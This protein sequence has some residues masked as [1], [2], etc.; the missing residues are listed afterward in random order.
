MMNDS[1]LSVPSVP[2]GQPTFPDL[3]GKRVLISG[4]GGG[5]GAA[6]SIG[7]L[8]QGCKV[9]VIDRDV[10]ALHAL[11]GEHPDL[12]IV[13]GDITDPATIDQAMTHGTVDVLVNNVANDMRHELADTDDATLQALFEVNLLAAMRLVRAVVPGMQAQSA[14]AILNIGSNS[15][16][17][18]LVGL[19]MY[20]ACK[21]AIHALT[22]AWAREYGSFDIRVN[23]LV[24]GW[25]FTDKQLRL[26][27]NPEAVAQCLEEQCLKTRLQPEDMIAPALF[28]AS[29]AA[30]SITGALLVA[31]AGRV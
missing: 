7:F 1:N 24:P 13:I 29:Q 20:V 8:R 12:Q 2:P 22:K 21:G 15:T 31:D 18:G 19:P 25:V 6:F 3:A 27:A 9:L 17:M 11:H 30:R 14:G 28:L 4:G 5:I 23:A 16:L 26:W 10:S